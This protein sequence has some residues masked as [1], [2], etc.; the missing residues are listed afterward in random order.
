MQEGADTLGPGSFVVLGAFDAL[1]VQIGFEPP[2]L[3]DEDV[4]EAFDVFDGAATFAGAGVEPDARMGRGARSGG[5]AKDDALVPPDGGGECGDAAEDLWEFQAEVERDEAAERGAAYA[6]TVDAGSDA[7]APLHERAN[8]FEKKFGVAI[9]AAATELGRA[10]G[11]VFT[12][13]LFAGVID[14]DD[15]ERL[16]AIFVDAVVGSLADMPIHARDEGSGAVEK[17]LAVVKIKDGIGALGLLVVAGREIDDEVAAIAQKARGEL[18]VLDEIW[19][20][21]GAM[22]RPA[23]G[24]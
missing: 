17:I 11:R 18:L 5:K 4:A 3:A 22:T 7:I 23:I 12:K 19:G 14:A 16:D 2:A 20:V 21:H 8:F 1:V 6:G 15:D 9:G 13:A 24:A 10:R